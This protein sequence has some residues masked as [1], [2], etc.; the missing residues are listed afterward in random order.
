M[1][2]NLGENNNCHQIDNGYLK[3]DVT[4]QKNDTTNF[5]NDDP[6]R[7]VNNGFAFCFKEARLSTTLR[8]DIETNKICGQVSSI[9]KVI[10]IKKVIYYINLIILT[11]MIFQFSR[12][13]LTYHLKLEI[14][15][16]KKR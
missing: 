1:N 2:F 12:E 3:F 15:L 13:L 11:R 16:T 5:H 8:S 6:I 7:L 10:S 14:H 4:V 9:M